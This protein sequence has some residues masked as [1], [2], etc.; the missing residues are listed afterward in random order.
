MD[1]KTNFIL[2][3]FIICW[4]KR[5]WTR[6]WTQASSDTQRKMGY[7]RVW[8]AGILGKVC[9]EFKSLSTFEKQTLLSTK[10]NLIH[11]WLKGKI[12]RSKTLSREV[13]RPSVSGKICLDNKRARKNLGVKWNRNNEILA[14]STLDTII[15]C[16]RK[17]KTNVPRLRTVTKTIF[18]PY[19]F[20]KLHY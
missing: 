14:T 8:H 6:F 2:I 15:R 7:R 10:S 17:Q 9:A 5:Y 18:R 12:W 11:F 19:Q 16:L 4:I 20:L 3:T 1:H 13:N